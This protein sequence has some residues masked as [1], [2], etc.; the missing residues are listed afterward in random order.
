MEKSFSEA[1][2]TRRSIYQLGKNTTVSSQ[3]IRE[4]LSNM[5]KYCPSAFNS[6]SGRVVL[7]LGEQHARLWTLVKDVL[8]RIVP[9]DA[10]AKTE[11][12]ID[13]FAKG[14]GSV[15][16]F[17]DMTVVDGLQKQF[18]LYAENFPRW[19]LQSNGMLEY[20]IWTALEA[21]GLGANLQHYNPLIDEAVKKEWNL[22]AEWELLAQMP[23]GSIEAPAGEKSFLPL[24]NRI[25]VFG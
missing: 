10:F 1:V 21:E 7:L 20:L 14:I 8:R 24:E 23:F 16:F 17:E 5:V 13:G 18:P 12:K 15:L 6:Q 25:K 19:S 9:A 2:E 22:P 3:R 11:Q 4:I